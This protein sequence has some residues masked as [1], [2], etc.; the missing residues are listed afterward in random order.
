MG[1]RAW[2]P[3]IVSSD[4]EKGWLQIDSGVVLVKS[5]T[6]PVDTAIVV[7][8]EPAEA[9]LQNN[10]PLLLTHYMPWYQTPDVSGYWGWHWTMNHFDPNQVDDDGRRQIASQFM[11]LTGAYDSQDDAILEYQ[12]LLM[13]LSGMDGVIV[14]WYGSSDANDY[15]V[16]NAA[17]GKLFDYIT[18]AG[19]QFAI[20]YEDRTILTMVNAGRLTTDTAITQGQADIQYANEHWF[21]SDAYVTHEGQPLVFIFG[22]LYFRQPSDWTTL[23]ADIDPA[24]ALVTLDG[25][26]DFAALSSYPWLPMEMAGGAELFPAVLESYLERFYRNAQRRD[27]IVGSAFP[28]FFDIYAEADVRSSYGY[29]SARNGDT[30]RETLDM[31]LAQ[32]SEIVQLVTW[33]DYGEG[34]TL[35]PTIEYGYQY[36]EIV[37]EARQKLDGGFAPTA[38]DLQLPMRLLQL[39]RAYAGDADIN[40]Q[41]DNVFSAIIAGDLATAR[42]ILD[43]FSP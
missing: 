21:N 11:P 29:L 16:L 18:R 43:A 22:P 26:M 24:P 12:V 34:T 2:L 4:S 27:F 32:N 36:L 17:T 9:T 25:H 37:Q 13:K 41:L 30:L 28:G 20:C 33:N 19:L 39:R 23:F 35:E 1:G 10:R 38:D 8:F 14:D 3:Q 40:A 42:E 15:G 31:A 5:G 7:A 6:V